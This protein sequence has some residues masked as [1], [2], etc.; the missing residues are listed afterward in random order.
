L[1]GRQIARQ[2]QTYR[3]P[4]RQ[5]RIRLRHPDIRDRHTGRHTDREDKRTN[6]QKS[7]METYMEID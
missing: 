2:R 6:G 3:Q 5:N 1:T 7:E 4:D